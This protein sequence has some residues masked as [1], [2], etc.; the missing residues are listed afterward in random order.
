VKV[1]RAALDE[2]AI[3]QIEELNPSIEFD[4]TRILKGGGAPPTEPR[5]PVEIRRHRGSEQRHEH[6]GREPQGPRTHIRVAPSAPVERESPAQRESLPEREPS[7]ESIGPGEVTATRDDSAPLL[8][9]EFTPLPP[10]DEPITPA[11]GKLGSEGVQRLRAR[12]AEICARISERIA[13]PSKK[14]EFAA[15]AE[16]LNPDTW[17]TADE[18]AAGLEQYETVLASLREVVGRNRRRRKRGGGRGEGQGPESDESDSG[19]DES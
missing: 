9:E 10:M 8:R 14:E 6:H 18:V 17:V 11:H 4:W 5:A 13:D 7:D 19:S 15:T 1:G 16:R 12:Y 3:R 2:D